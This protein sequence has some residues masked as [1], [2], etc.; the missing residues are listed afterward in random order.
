MTAAIVVSFI[1]ELLG[2]PLGL[3]MV[4]VGMIVSAV[5]VFVVSILTQHSKTEDVDV[6]ERTAQVQ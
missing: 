3:D 1:W 6:L 2:N 5:T 4:I